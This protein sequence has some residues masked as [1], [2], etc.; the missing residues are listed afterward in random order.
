MGSH[1]YIVQWLLGYGADPRTGIDGEAIDIAQRAAASGNMEA[2]ETILEAERA[3]DNQVNLNLIISFG[4][5]CS[6]VGML[7][8][9]LKSAELPRD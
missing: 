4:A 7:N 9:G 1:L 5:S 8:L 6:N 2:F 3:A